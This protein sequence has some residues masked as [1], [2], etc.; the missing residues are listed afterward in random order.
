MILTCSV[1]ADK[2]SA[3]AA[4][5]LLFNLQAKICIVRCVSRAKT[6]LFDEGRGVNLEVGQ[7]SF[8]S[9]GEAMIYFHVSDNSSAPDSI[10]MVEADETTQLGVEV[11]ARQMR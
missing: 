4:K 5:R 2:D 8:Q 6:I 3:V 10:A 11:H 1:M 9:D 7:Q